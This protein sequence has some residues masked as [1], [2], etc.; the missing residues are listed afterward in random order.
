MKQRKT[1]FGYIIKNGIVTVDKTEADIVREIAKQYLGGSSLKTIA[2]GLTLRTIEYM[3][4]KSDWNKSRIRRMIDDTR[5]IGN[6]G[7]PPI[8]TEQEY[9]AMQAFKSQKNTQKNIDHSDN[10]FKL[11]APVVCAN[12]GGRMQRHI[13]NRRKTITRWRCTECK[14]SVNISD[15]DMLGGITELLNEVIADPES[16][17]IPKSDYEE[18]QEI[19]RLNAEIS[20]ELNTVGFDKEAI[21][22]KM[23][24]C[25]SEKYMSLGTEEVT[26]Q[27]LK[28]IFKDTPPLTAYDSD[29]TDQA[30]SGIQLKENGTISL[31]LINGQRIGKEKSA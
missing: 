13:D 7:Y 27:S 31:V 6:N 1:P 5:Y 2:G 15:E 17:Q 14:T 3:P 4:G 9:S 11:N 28:D 10:I 16:I 24:T 29:L 30:V 19:K 23:L 21:K 26:A 18:S 20:K 12:C 25:V 22:Q 8:L